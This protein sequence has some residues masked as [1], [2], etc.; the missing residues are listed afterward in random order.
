MQDGEPSMSE[1][2]LPPQNIEAEQSVL[3]SIL[4]D[5]DAIVRVAGFL[6]PDDFYREA[7]RTIY[8]AARDLFER[9]E[10]ADLVLMCDELER[11]GR[12]EQVGGPAY[13][14]SLINMVPTAVNV[15]FYGH[16]VERCAVLRRLITAGGQI[17]G[18]AY[19]YQD[20]AEMAIDRAEQILFS[21]TQR[22]RAREF[23]PISEVLDKYFNEIDLIHQNRGQTF[24]VPTG[25]TKLD[26]LTGGLQRSDLVVLAARPG[27]GK[28]SFALN[29]AAHAAMKNNV[30]VG[31]FSLEMSKDQLVQRLICSHAGIDSQR[32]RNGFIQDDEWAKIAQTIGELS[33]AP[34]YIDDTPGIPVMELRTKARRL[35]AEHDLGFVIVD[36]LQLMQGRRTEN[37]VQ[38]VSDISRSL[39]EL[40]REL[41]IP[42]LAASQLNRSVEQRPRN[43]PQLSDLRESGCLAGETLVYL[44]EEGTY[45]RI[46][47]LVGR[48]GFNVLALNEKTYRL[49]PRPVV[50]A[51]ATGR[52]PVF[53]LMTR[54]GRSVRATANHKFL[55]IRGW[56]RLDEL[57]PGDRIALPRVLP[58]PQLSTMSD[59]ELALLGHLIGDG[60]TLPRQPIHYT[61]NDPELAEIV[62]ILAT[63]VFGSSVKPRVSV[64]RSWIQVYLAATAHLTHGVRNPVAKWIDEMDVFGLR[65]F[66][67]RVPERVFAQPAQGVARFLR[68]LWATDGAIWLPE[69]SAR[70]DPSIYYA[71][72]SSRLACDVQSLLLRLGINA[73]VHCSP[74]RGR[75]RAQFHVDIS[76]R[77]DMLRFAECIGAV[78]TRRKTVLGRI[79]ALLARRPTNTNRDV[80][81]REVWRLHAVPAMKRRA[82]TTRGM[83]ESLGNRYCG[84]ALY[85]QNVSRDRAA[86]LAGVVCSP[87]LALLASSDVYWDEIAF[88]SPDG[89]AD[90]FDLTIDGPHNFVANDI[91][92]HNS[93]EQDADI[94]MFIS[95]EEIY[96]PE[97]TRK[98]TADVIVAKHRNGPTA[99][100]ELKF[101]NSQT[102]FANVVE[103]RYAPAR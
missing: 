24:G 48:T 95:R 14:T 101:I 90:V 9:R 36:Y 93:I 75:G 103:D 47:E 76:G 11:R 15:E 62:S 20:D 34:I 78:D 18:T 25:F 51:F 29:I 40:A 19:D 22:R 35:Q 82:L 96:D 65:S 87:Q 77:T 42:V 83:Q 3:G 39:K 46:D 8:H 102:R 56:R 67:K 66:E 69:E 57:S 100:I 86:R 81:P 52:K 33:E 92:V 73:V 37:R 28:T 26:E 99:D 54:L 79:V 7:H 98:G 13:L 55:T 63:N 5:R 88:I 89:D 64:E 59:A 80:I 6:M 74:Q 72:S 70:P 50:N 2:R 32:L 31:I 27:M 30:P 38:E 97:T 4:I 53:D 17:A 10:P 60:C 44:P 12:L 43:R 85:K 45:R 94:V 84:T 21:L 1:E 68:H 91:T 16:V 61:T 71:T 49:E 41:N 58:G 23:V